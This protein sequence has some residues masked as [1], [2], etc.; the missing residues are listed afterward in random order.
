MLMRFLAG[1]VS[2]NQMRPY[3]RR[4]A[5]AAAGLFVVDLLRL[6]GS[7]LLQVSSSRALIDRATSFGDL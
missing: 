3:R 5:P 4:W 6:A 7:W 1:S 2:A